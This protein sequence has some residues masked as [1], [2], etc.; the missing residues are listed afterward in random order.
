MGSGL[1]FHPNPDISGLWE[2]PEC[3]T[4]PPN[5]GYSIQVN[6]TSVRLQPLST[7]STAASP[8]W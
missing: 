2:C 7:L 3:Q 6:F 5:A 4:W 1:T 8:P